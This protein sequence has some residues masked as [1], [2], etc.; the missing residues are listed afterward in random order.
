MPISIDESSILRDIVAVSEIFSHLDADNAVSEPLRLHKCDFDDKNIF[1]MDEI[2]FCGE[3]VIHGTTIL[4]CVRIKGFL[5]CWVA[6]MK[7]KRYFLW[8]F[9]RADSR[10]TSF[11][12]AEKSDRA[13]DKN[14]MLISVV[15]LFYGS[16]FAQQWRMEE[17]HESESDVE[18]RE[19]ITYSYFCHLKQTTFVKCTLIHEFDMGV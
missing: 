1:Q 9:S 19:F 2:L 18:F 13:S 8:I 3:W 15:K 12:A 7:G 4:L 16:S 10:K 14:H 17:A 5:G 6:S 11:P